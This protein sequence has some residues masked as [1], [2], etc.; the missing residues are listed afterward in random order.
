MSNNSVHIFHDEKFTNIIV[1][2]FLKTKEKNQRFIVLYENDTIQYTIDQDLPIE[3]IQLRTNQ[4][5]LLINNLTNFSHIFIH[6]LCDI[7][8]KIIDKAPLTSKII[9]MCWGQDI[10]KLIIANSYTSRTSFLL[11]KNK[12]YKE[13]FWKYAYWLLIIKFQFSSKKQLLKKIDF[14]CPV[15]EEDLLLTNKRLGLNIKFLP[16]RYGALDD[17]LG[18][19][20][21]NKCSGNNILI[22]N[23]STYASNHLD[24][25]YQ[26]QQLSIS[27]QKI[28]IPLNYGNKNYGNQIQDYANTMFSGKTIILRNYLP[29]TEYNSI[30]SNC[31]IAIFN[32]VR[33]Q[34][35][36]NIIISLWIG[37]RVY[38]NE[39]SLLYLNLKKMGLIIFSIKKDLNIKT[40]SVLTKLSEKDRLLNKTILKKEFGEDNTINLT[41]NIFNV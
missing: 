17:I 34:A 38:L 25:L 22:G 21:N 24:T 11:L 16:F 8:L 27:N 3:K 7:K 20:N 31:S 40:I 36:G 5:N 14:C 12:L 33:Q 10:H 32:H 35:L 23:S 30:L 19:H 4:Y 26:L 13:Y 18:E 6:F 9:W 2:Q 37:A 39:T 29:I 41:R 1:R 28:V 15:I